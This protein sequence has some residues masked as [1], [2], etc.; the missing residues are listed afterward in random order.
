MKNI[1][2]HSF[3]PFESV[4]V[5]SMPVKVNAIDILPSLSNPAQKLLLLILKKRAINVAKITL[6]EYKESE[7][8][9]GSAGYYEAIRELVSRNIVAAAKIPIFY[10]NPKYF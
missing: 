6:K 8:V 1:E 5:E 9:I 3:N 7:G 10:I 2:E 4:D